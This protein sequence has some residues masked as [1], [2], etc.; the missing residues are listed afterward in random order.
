MKRNIFV[1]PDIGNTL[2]KFTMYFSVFFLV[3]GLT[4]IIR[5][6]GDTYAASDVCPAGWNELSTKCYK[7]YS[8]KSECDSD[9]NDGNTYGATCVATYDS[10][11]VINGYKV[12]LNIVEVTYDYD[13]GTIV[14]SSERT[15][16]GNTISLPSLHKVG[17]TSLGW[18]YNGSN[19]AV[20]A[21][22][23]NDEFPVNNDISLYARWDA[24]DFTVTYN[25][26][27]G[28]PVKG[29][30]TVEYNKTGTFPNAGRTGYKLTGW[31]GK[32]SYCTESADNPIYDVGESTPVIKDNKTYYACWNE[33]KY[34][35]T[36]D[37]NGGTV[38][39]STVSVRSGETYTLPT[40]TRTGYTFGGWYKN[41]VGSAASDV[42]EKI[43]VSADTL[44]VADWKV[45]EYILFLIVNK[46]NML[47]QLKVSMVLL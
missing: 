20:R 13:G 17:H 4:M 42:G 22:S 37:A 14:R 43:T 2:K 15:Y 30:E 12:E 10:D 5:N 46:V 1:D 26:N 23:G 19:G 44:L 33:V 31:T 45:N 40:P 36:L 41:Y 27:G 29:S 38:S 3:F 34:T 6:A 24:D 11:D 28:N 25:G 9:Y 7:Y 16:K 39:P 21:G 35:V 32:Y 47:L 18:Y 8:T